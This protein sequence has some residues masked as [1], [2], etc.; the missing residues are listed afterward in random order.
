MLPQTNLQLYG[1]LIARGLDEPTLTQVRAVYDLA[2]Q[3][4]AGC[5][6]PTHKA[7]DAH[8]IGA[9]GA[10]AMW[11][12]PLPVVLA[13]LLHSAY[14]YGEFGDGARGITPSRRQVVRNIVGADA[15]AL[16]ADYTN[17]RWPQEIGQ[18]YEEVEAGKLSAQLLAITLADLCD[19]C[20]DGGPRYAP[21]KPLGF[22]LPGDAAVR[23][24]FFALVE[25]VAGAGARQLFADVLSSCDEVQPP[26]TLIN[27]DRSFHAVATGVDGLRLSIVRRKLHRLSCRLL[28]KRA[29]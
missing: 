19:E 29:A 18:F 6:R 14:L 23:T 20:L 9:A 11:G 4:F 3:L 15:E 28:R 24:P 26:A 13:G 27:S 5:Y 22:G 17:Q 21:V 2:R 1:A 8:L 16:I 12:Q 7:F 10:L 25:R